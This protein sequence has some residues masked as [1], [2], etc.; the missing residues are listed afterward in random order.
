MWTD[1][2]RQ[3]EEPTVQRE[4]KVPA[5]SIPQYVA[6]AASVLIAVAIGWLTFGPRFGHGEHHEFAAEFGHYLDEFRRDPDAAQQFLLAKYEGQAVTPD[7]AVRQVG[8][9]PAIVD[10]VPDGYT[11]ESTYVMTMPCCKCV[12]TVCRRSDGSMI[13]VFEHDDEAPEWFGDRPTTAAQCSGKACSLVDIDDRI[14]ASW[15][16]GKRHITVIGVRDVAEVEQFA[17]VFN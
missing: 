3:L 13:T 12:Q 5:W 10:G 7:Q 15:Q 14:A 6:M 2:Q 9:R 17:A 16:R 1:I 11:V 8:Y 4:S